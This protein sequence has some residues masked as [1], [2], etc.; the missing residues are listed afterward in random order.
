MSFPLI[1][2]LAAIASSLPAAY[3]LFRIARAWHADRRPV[4]RQAVVAA[5]LKLLHA[6][7]ALYLQE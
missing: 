2:I 5:V 6:A 3:Q 4:D 7:V 1:S